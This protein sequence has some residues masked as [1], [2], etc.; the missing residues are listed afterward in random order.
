MSVDIHDGLM[1]HEL[2]AQR[3]DPSRAFNV[4]VYQVGARCCDQ[5]RHYPGW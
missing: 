1:L 3:M 5:P 4:N 2:L